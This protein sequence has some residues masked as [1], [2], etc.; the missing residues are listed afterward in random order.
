MRPGFLRALLNFVAL[1]YRCIACN[2]D[3][4]KQLKPGTFL[5]HSNI[6][7]S[8]ST[9][10]LKLGRWQCSPTSWPVEINRS[11]I[12]RWLAKRTTH[13]FATS[14]AHRRFQTPGAIDRHASQVRYAIANSWPASAARGAAMSRLVETCSS[15]W[16]THSRS[17]GRSLRR[18]LPERWLRERE[19]IVCGAISRRTLVFG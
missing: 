15:R 3:L 5:L 6:H 9:N 10:P 18:R 4:G 12:G 1:L 14:D 16:D 13:R 11:A 7:G 17:S 19:S 2:A 8:S